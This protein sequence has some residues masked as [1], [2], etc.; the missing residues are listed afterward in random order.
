MQNLA[1]S[2][3]TNDDCDIIRDEIRLTPYDRR[4]L[5]LRKLEAKRDA[6][7]AN[8]E[9]SDR[10]RRRLAIVQFQVSKAQARMDLELDRDRDEGWRK[11]HAIDEWREGDGREQRNTSRRKVRNH[12][13]DNLSELTDVEKIKRKKYQ[14]ADANWFK[15]CRDKGMSEP[16]ITAAYAVRCD[17]RTCDNADEKAMRENPNYGVF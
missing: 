11:L 14:R 1:E 7:L 8:P 16:M 17:T 5:E 10:D 15:R 13:N 4:R 3:D 9:L 12:A 2:Q 6:I